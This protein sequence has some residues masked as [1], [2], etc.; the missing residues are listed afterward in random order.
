MTAQNSNETINFTTSQKSGLISK[1]FKNVSPIGGC[2]ATYNLVIPK[3]KKGVINEGYLN[4]W[5][6]GYETFPKPFNSFDQ[7]KDRQS[8]EIPVDYFK[9]ATGNGYFML[10]ELEDGN[11][12]SILPLVSKNMMAFINMDGGKPH[13][14]LATFGTQAYSGTVP[15]LSYAYAN[16]PYTATQKSWELALQ[17]EF[18]KDNVQL[19]SNKTY[20][21][22]Y[23]YLG[24]CTWEAYEGGITEEIVI[25]SINTIKKSEVP[26]RWL[27]VDDGYLDQETKGATRPQLLSFDTNSKFPNGWENITSLK[28][29]D[30]VKW[31]GIW[32][33]MSG[34]MYGVSKNHTMTALNDYLEPSIISN[35]TNNQKSTEWVETMVVK[36]GTKASEQ[37]YNAMTANTKVSGFDFQK[38]DF[39][40]F[41][42]WMYANSDNAVEKAHQNNQ[43]LEKACKDNNIELLNCISQSNVNVFNTKYSAISRASVDIKLHLPKEN[44]RRTRQSFANNM[45]WGDIIYGDL[46]MYHTSNKETAQY[47]TIARAISG[48]PI[49]ISD[50]PTEFDKDVIDPL[51]FDDGKIIR[52][53]A[54]A[55]PLHESL[56]SNTNDT[57]Y[58]VIAP[59]REKS[60][61]IAAFNFSNESIIKAS[62]NADDYQYAS[63]KEQPFN[64]LWVMPNEGLVLYDYEKKAGDRLTN[65]HH[66]EVENMKGKIFTLS[67]IIKGWAVIGRSDKYISGCTYRIEKQT[68]R[69]LTLILDES[70]PIVVYSATQKPQTSHGIVKSIGKGFYSIEL[71]TGEKNKKLT[72][73]K[74]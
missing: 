65:S 42:F 10:L 60:C 38:V 43:A 27:I 7:F 73:Y 40:T 59:G 30:N 25:N 32:R 44:M 16:D 6:S 71:S 56:F 72:L 4:N 52:T 61:T 1:S 19:R 18:C 28:E 26:V 9:N 64:G 74:D 35:T 34:G 11:F 47:L 24:W 20:P 49:Y 5:V 48:G 23:E 13:L 17:S 33:N 55:V 51:I 66:F 8:S 2:V 68:K 37:F 22:M 50:K 70:G 63:A 45:W 58:R 3:I 67:P 36:P 39:Q 62:I 29:D 46:D 54:P 15:L 53:L 41:N 14:K 57:A 21:E 12:L 31:M 69:K